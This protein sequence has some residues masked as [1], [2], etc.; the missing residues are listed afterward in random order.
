MIRDSIVRRYKIR[1]SSEVKER[2][3]IARSVNE[4]EFSESIA[5]EQ[6]AVTAANSNSELWWHRALISNSIVLRQRSSD[7][8][9]HESCSSI[10]L[11]WR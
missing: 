11:S 5:P 4:L 6:R 1:I 3:P 9:Q 8:N 2:A 10:A 7:T